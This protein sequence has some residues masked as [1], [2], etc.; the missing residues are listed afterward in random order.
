MHKITNTWD[1]AR[2][3]NCGVDEKEQNAADIRGSFIELMYSNDFAKFKYNP[4]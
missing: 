2:S 3:F 1:G 4:K